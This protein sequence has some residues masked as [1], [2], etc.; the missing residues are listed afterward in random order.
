MSSPGLITVTIVGAGYAGIAQ[1]VQLKRRLGGRIAVRVVE[2]ADGPGGIWKTSTWPGAGVDIPI[3]LYSLY[4]D[5]VGDWKNVFA[6]QKDVLSYLEGLIKKHSQSE[7]RTWS[8]SRYTKLIGMSLCTDIE[9]WFEYDTSYVSSTWDPATQQHTI[10]L[11]PLNGDPYTIKSNILIS[12]NGPLSTPQI[13]NIP[14]LDSFSKPYFHNLRWRS[15]LDFAGK[16]IAVVGNGSSGIQFIP[17]LAELPGT[18]VVQYIRSGG[19][20]F[21]KKN[22]AFSEWDRFVFTWVPGAR[23]LHRTRLFIEVSGGWRRVARVA[24]R[25][26][27]GLSSGCEPGLTVALLLSPLQSDRRWTARNDSKAEGHDDLEQGLL[28]YL[29]DNAPAKYLDKLIPKY[30]KPASSRRDLRI[31]SLSADLIHSFHPQR[32]AASAPPST[33]A[34]SPRSIAPTS[35]SATRP[36]SASRR[37]RSSPRTARRSSPTLSSLRPARMLRAMESG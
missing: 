30:R 26:E 15:D 17:G 27:G 36:S 32:S 2:K 24:A 18:E 6:E 12:A 3:H 5:T 13:P 8:C 7:A 34:G 31:K 16:R 25:R 33:P 29:T 35:T 37:M 4:S 14:G 28:K 11:Q 19:Y 20:F 1:A 10:T 9:S 23:W 22:T 21:P